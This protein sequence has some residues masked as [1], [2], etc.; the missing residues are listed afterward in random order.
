MSDRVYF[1]Y[2]QYIRDRHDFR[3]L[4]QNPIKRVWRVEKRVGYA[5]AKLFRCKLLHASLLAYSGY[6]A[7]LSPEKDRRH[8]DCHGLSKRFSRWPRVDPKTTHYESTDH[9]SRN[10]SLWG[11]TTLHY[12]A[13]RR[14]TIYYTMYCEVLQCATTNDTTYYDALGRT[15]TY[16]GVLRGTR[17]Y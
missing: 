1:R 9:G 13:L 3:Q 2:I 7:L 8:M 10:R 17:T 14:T 15:I 5:S 16:Y 6:F 11:R 12:V 4:R